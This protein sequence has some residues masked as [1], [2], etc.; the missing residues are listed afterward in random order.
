MYLNINYFVFNSLLGK[1]YFIKSLH[2]KSILITIELNTYCI[3]I[4]IRVNLDLNLLNRVL[5]VRRK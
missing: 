3:L 4:L 1:I 2:V 5:G